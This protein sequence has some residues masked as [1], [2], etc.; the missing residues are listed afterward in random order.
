MGTVA[1]T[2]AQGGSL[3]RVNP[4]VDQL[5]TEH[6]HL[7]KEKSLSFILGLLTSP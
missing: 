1:R 2:S 6:V 3:Q 7:D 5:P 4:G